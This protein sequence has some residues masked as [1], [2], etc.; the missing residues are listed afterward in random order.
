[1]PLRARI[2][3]GRVP[4]TPSSRKPPAIARTCSRASPKLVRRQPSPDRS[5]SQVRPGASRAQRS[6]AWVM[7]V[8]SPENGVGLVRISSPPPLSSMSSCGGA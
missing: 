1:M 4:T 2:S 3:S 5:A 8:N 7:V 6:S